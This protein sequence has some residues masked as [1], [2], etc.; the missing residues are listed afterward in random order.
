VEHSNETLAELLE[1]LG[2]MEEAIMLLTRQRTVKDWYT[3]AEIAEMLGKAEFTVREWCR[4]G[5]LHAEKRRSGR[6]P[7]PAWVISQ[8]EVLRYQRE[9]LLPRHSHGVA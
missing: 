3:T 1:R 9:G 8:T 4:H 5:R 2:R 6:G 7:F